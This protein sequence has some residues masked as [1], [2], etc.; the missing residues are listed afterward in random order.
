MG[1]KQ[2][3]SVFQGTKRCNVDILQKSAE[4]EF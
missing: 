2:P 1:K 4:T 3:S